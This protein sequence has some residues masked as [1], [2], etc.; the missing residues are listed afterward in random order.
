MFDIINNKEVIAMFRK[1]GKDKQLDVR[2]LND[3]LHLSNQILRIAHIFLII[4][5]IYVVTI[6][7]KE[8]NVKPTIIILLKTLAPLFIGLF[9]AWLFDPFVRYLQKKGIKRSLGTAITY[10]LFLGFLALVIGSIIPVLSDQINDFVKTIPTVF[11]TVK[12]WIDVAFDKFKNID[13]FDAANMQAQLSKKIEAFGT[14]LTDSL[15]ELTVNF[16]KTF[17]S[18][19]GTFLIGLIIGFYLLISFNNANDLIITLLPNRMRKEA[20][21]L[22][23]QVNG[24]LRKFVQ[25]AL[26]DSTLIFLVSSFGLWLCGLRAP[27]LFGLFCGIT[28]VIPY[29][30]PYIGGAPAVIVGFSQSPTIGICALVTIVIIQFLEGNFLQPLI[31]SKTTKLHPVTIILGLL[32]FGYFFGIFGMVI[33]TPIIGAC[34][35]IFFFFDEK[36]HLLNYNNEEVD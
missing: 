14:N 23:Y 6:I 13:N 19:A 16:I 26:A 4:G 18:W 11:D 9:I 1:E 8:W 29:A 34:K 36:Y 24:T 27:L 31:M 20:K 30:G 15:P 25:G 22:I 35:A 12:N 5:A 7:M 3:L 21:E 32:V 2:S 28:N 33:S 17:F 10:I